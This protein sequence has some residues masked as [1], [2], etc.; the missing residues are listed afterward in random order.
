MKNTFSL[1]VTALL[2]L[3]AIA[4]H[5]QKSYA[6]TFTALPEKM[7]ETPRPLLIKVY[8]DWCSICK[9]QDK[10]IEKDK[11]LQAV[12]ANQ[13][14]YLE[15]NAES[16]EAVSF[17]GKVYRFIPHGVSGGIHELAMQLCNKQA[18]YPCWVLL[19]K[20]Y[21]TRLLYNG[22]IQAKDLKHLLKE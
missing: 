4:G 3:T 12:L 8:T 22:L 19:S 13:Y 5:S 9:I 6:V 10:K 1:A 11:E 14:Y 18:A 2:L 21:K 17:N 15:L 7:A 16:T 20:D